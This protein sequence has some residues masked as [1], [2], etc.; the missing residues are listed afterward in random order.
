MFTL[1]PEIILLNDCNL[2][3]V[4]CIVAMVVKGCDDIGNLFDALISSSEFDGKTQHVTSRVLAQTRA[5]T[6]CD[7]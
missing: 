7:I 4:R 1:L 5:Q 3:A 6:N 2:W